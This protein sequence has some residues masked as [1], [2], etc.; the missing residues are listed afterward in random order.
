MRD[1]TS[2][3]ETSVAGFVPAVS[4]GSRLL[5]E[6]PNVGEFNRAI[7]RHPLSP[8]QI[9]LIFPPAIHPMS[10]ALSLGRWGV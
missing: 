10:E 2:R 3:M 9:N 6:V 8:V 1:S 7:N 5:P 4:T